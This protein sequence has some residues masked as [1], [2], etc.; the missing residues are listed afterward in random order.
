MEHR[1]HQR[2]DPS[3]LQPA[4][5]LAEKASES[6]LI[7]RVVSHLSFIPIQ[8]LILKAYR[9]LARLSSQLTSHFSPGNILII[10]EHFQYEHPCFAP[11]HPLLI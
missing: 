5:F 11:Q 6:F 4:L 10:E 3:L 2:V 9:K 1:L 8:G 7:V